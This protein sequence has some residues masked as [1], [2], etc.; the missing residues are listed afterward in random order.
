MTSN[1][2]FSVRFSRAEKRRYPGAAITTSC[3]PAG[4]CS[5]EKCP[6]SSVRAERSLAGME[7]SIPASLRRVPFSTTVPDRPALASTA[8]STNSSID[9][10]PST[11]NEMQSER[12]RGRYWLSLKTR[13]RKAQ[14]RR[15]PQGGLAQAI[16][17]VGNDL[18]SRHRSARVEPQPQH[19]GCFALFAACF[20]RIEAAQV[21][22][23]D[24]ARHL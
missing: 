3:S 17:W 10:S 8:A 20:G 5:S 21:R 18:R 7:T 4:S 6:S 22:L 12:H 2:W 13:R 19:H 23:C 16:A 14:L 15:G 11:Q 1:R 9:F 24:Q